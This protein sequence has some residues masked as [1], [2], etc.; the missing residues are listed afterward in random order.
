MRNI[1]GRLGRLSISMRLH[2]A[3]VTAVLA[4]GALLAGGYVVGCDRVQDARVASLR[5]V[6]ESAAGIASAFESEERLGRLDREQAQKLALA[7]IRAIRYSGKEYV[8][9]NDMR[10][11]MIMHPVKPELD[12]RDLGDMQDPNGKR[13][14]TEMAE[15]VRTRH[16]GTVDYL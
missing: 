16:S 9:V 5:V 4:I 2:L 15:V 7:A 8:W 14:F 1:R 3:T 10:P 13:L 12:G 11:R 6:V